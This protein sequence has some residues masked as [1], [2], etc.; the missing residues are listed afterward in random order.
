MARGRLRLGRFGDVSVTLLQLNGHRGAGVDRLDL[1]LELLPG[2]W[3]LFHDARTIM[4]SD[5]EVGPVP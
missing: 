3:E 2:Q 4:W 5:L 1:A